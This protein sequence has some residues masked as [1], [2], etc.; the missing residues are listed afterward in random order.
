MALITYH[1]ETQ[2]IPVFQIQDKLWLNVKN[3]TFAQIELLEKWSIG[4]GNNYGYLQKII[5]F[6][7]CSIKPYFAIVK[8]YHDSGN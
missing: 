4:L 2:M 8:P 5:L 3:C 6:L 7:S 1:I